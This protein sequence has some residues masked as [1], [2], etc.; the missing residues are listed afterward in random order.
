MAGLDLGLVDTKFAELQGSA[1]MSKKIDGPKDSGAKNR[2]AAIAAREN[3]LKA[4]QQAERDRINAIRDANK[5]QLAFL[6]T[7]DAKLHLWSGRATRVEHGLHIVSE[8]VKEGV[9]LNAGDV[10]ENTALHRAVASCN[11]EVVDMLISQGA[12][13]HAKNC[14]GLAPLH[15]AAKRSDIVTL[16]ALL[17]AGADIE[18]RDGE[19]FTPLLRSAHYGD[20]FIV[21]VLLDEGADPRAIVQAP[22]DK[23]GLAGTCPSAIELAREGGNSTVLRLL[24][25]G[26][27]ITVKAEHDLVK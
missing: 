25:G 7:G 20:A 3:A 12:N 22:E 11:H 14:F 15:V 16:R 8:L 4:K 10:V 13:V 21:Q 27:A 26:A 24:S 5:Q 19:G 6:D 9:D 18:A 2:I 1:I 23:D 17:S